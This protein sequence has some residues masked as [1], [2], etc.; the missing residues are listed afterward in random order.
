MGMSYKY[1]HD[2][3]K[4]QN[5]ERQCIIEK[6]N[7]FEISKKKKKAFLSRQSLFVCLVVNIRVCFNNFS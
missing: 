6:R 2:I 1:E 3:N 7:M 5:N 4:S